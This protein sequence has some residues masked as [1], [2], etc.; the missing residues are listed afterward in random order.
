M[1]SREKPLKN[2]L[3]SR[4]FFLVAVLLTLVVITAFLRA[5]YQDYQIRQEIKS[6]QDEVALLETKKID[7]LDVLTY[8]KSDKYAEEKARTELNLI[9]PGEKMMIIDVD[10]KNARQENYDMV[11]SKNNN[12]N[13][14]KWWKFFFNK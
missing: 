5:F 10:I 6:L 4:W 2:F 14:K 7:T 9:N 12:S 11:K 1:S 8:V 3:N 13:L